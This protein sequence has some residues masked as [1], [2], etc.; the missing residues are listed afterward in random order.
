MI[1]AQEHSDPV[2]AVLEAYG[3]G[4]VLFRGKIVDV[5]RQTSE[6]FVRG[7]F[8]VA[9]VSTGDAPGAAAA[10]GG[11]GGG[12]SAAALPGVA[13]VQGPPEEAAG[14]VAA[15]T[16][17]LLT[18]S[19]RA[20]V[21][22]GEEE[23]AVIFQNENLL[24]YRRKLPSATSATHSHLEGGSTVNP[25]TAAGV[26]ATAAAA[27]AGAPATAAG[28]ASVAEGVTVHHEQQ[29]QQSVVDKELLAVVPDLICCLETETGEAVAT[30]ALRY[31]LKV[32]QGE[33]DQSVESGV[34]PIGLGGGTDVQTSKSV[35]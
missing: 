10:A 6:G 25:T 18:G 29:Q 8:I 11:D 12:R 5:V 13:G 21:L 4:K 22:G 19:G 35:A 27:A 33:V 26:P 31:G 15:A 20:A 9:G 3:S 32:R 23:L 14:P 1:S 7:S 34:G 2:A 30:E 28:G 17:S 24:A 16:G